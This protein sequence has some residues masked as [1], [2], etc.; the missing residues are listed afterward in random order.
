MGSSPITETGPKGLSVRVGMPN[1]GKLIFFIPFIFLRLRSTLLKKTDRLIQIQ[2]TL[3]DSFS[4]DG[5]F[6]YTLGNQDT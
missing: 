5:V 1:L 4:A 2:E 3:A 6:C